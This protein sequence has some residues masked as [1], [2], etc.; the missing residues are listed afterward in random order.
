MSSSSDINSLKENN[1]HPDISIVIGVGL[2]YPGSYR[3]V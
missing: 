3:K 1:I 2:K